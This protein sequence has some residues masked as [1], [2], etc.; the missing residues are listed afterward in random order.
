MVKGRSV[1][2]LQS[3]AG[4][5][6][7]LAEAGRIMG[8]SLDIDTVYQRFAKVIGRLMPFELVV[9]A[10]LGPGTDEITV[11]HIAGEHVPWMQSG[12]IRRWDQTVYDVPA[13]RSGGVIT[14]KAEAV[15]LANEKGEVDLRRVVDR[16]VELKAYDLRTANVEVK[17][18]IPQDPAVTMA[19]EHLLTQV[20][21]NIVT[22]AE[23]VLNEL[24]DGRKIA[25]WM[26]RGSDYFTISV[27]DN[28]Q[29]IAPE[30]VNRVFDPFFTTKE[31]GEGTG[32][33]LSMAYGIVRQ[34]DGEI[35][36]ESPPGGGTSFHIKIPVRL[37]RDG[38]QPTMHQTPAQNGAEE[39]SG[40]VLVVDDEPHIREFIAAA[41]SRRGYRVDVARNSQEALILMQD[42]LYDCL[43]LDLKMPG[44][45]GE[46]L[47]GFISRDRPDLAH[48][49][50]FMT[51]DTVS[52]RT[53][54]FLTGTGQPWLSKPVQLQELIGEVAMVCE[55]ADA[56]APKL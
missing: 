10:T 7:A 25:I 6:S 20:L 2:P 44:M 22:N 21:L 32:L 55:L 47:F 40:R 23:Q 5:N 12:T 43:V 15:R 38:V 24:A 19:D 45:S 51:G 54:D 37:A 4:E 36:V 41:L 1:S 27:S 28:G 9:I 14:S 11:A 8:S 56:S 34:H 39:G 35:S 30:V 31:V 16:V 17:I 26:S 49:V 29:G 48:R 42:S 46:D 50:V 18:D 3:L 52:K 53:R 13:F 33:G